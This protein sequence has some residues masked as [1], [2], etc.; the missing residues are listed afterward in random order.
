[1]S[2]TGLLYLC[3]RYILFLMSSL[4]VC[5]DNIHI[6]TYIYIYIYNVYFVSLLTVKRADEMIMFGNQ[7]NAPKVKKSD[8][9]MPILADLQGSVRALPPQ[10]IPEEEENRHVANKLAEAEAKDVEMQKE[11]MGE[12]ASQIQQQDEQK[13]PDISEEVAPNSS[14]EVVNAEDG[15][16]NNNAEEIEN[17]NEDSEMVD[18][19]ESALDNLAEDEGSDTSTGESSEDSVSKDMSD[20]SPSQDYLYDYLDSLY[21]KYPIYGRYTVHQYNRTELR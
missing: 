3:Y 16:D 6:Y 7:Q 15:D 20:E 12:L 13:S 18:S 10:H 2:L 1:M 9:N 21:G 5:R 4:V 17:S 11:A 14:E 19:N 8:P